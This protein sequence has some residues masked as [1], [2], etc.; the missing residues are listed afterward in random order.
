[1]DEDA[2]FNEALR[3]AMQLSTEE[4]ERKRALDKEEEQELQIAFLLSADEH[5]CKTE[6]ESQT[7]DTS[8]EES[9]SARKGKNRAQNAR[10]S[11]EPAGQEPE[12]E[13]WHKRFYDR[14]N[15]IIQFLG[16]SVAWGAGLI[17]NG[18]WTIPREVAE[19]YVWRLPTAFKQVHANVCRGQT[20]KRF[21]TVA[22]SNQLVEQRIL[23]VRARRFDQAEAANRR[24]EVFQ[25]SKEDNRW[26]KDDEPPKK[27]KR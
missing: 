7:I 16:A 24:F 14:M 23:E 17:R 6:E 8:D 4:Y 13:N 27:R 20:P 12:D 3:R 15:N 2:L 19:L 10:G 5:K 25:M 9:P 11:T 22:Y 26:E 18:K 21:F 1:M